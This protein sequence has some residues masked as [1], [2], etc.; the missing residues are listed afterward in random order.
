MLVDGVDC[1]ELVER[2]PC[3]LSECTTLVDAPTTRSVERATLPPDFSFTVITVVDSASVV[4]TSAATSAAT[5]DANGEQSAN[6]VVGGLDLIAWI[7]IGVGAALLVALAVGVLCYVRRRR[8][9]L[10]Q[11][12]VD[13]VLPRVANEPLPIS[14]QVLTNNA[15][16]MSSGVGDIEENAVRAKPKYDSVPPPGY[17]MPEGEP[18]PLY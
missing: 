2:V 8:R 15:I 7:L 17:D 18:E 3:V 1:P 4:A 10:L 13:T 12:D 14:P 9:Y 11:Q 16:L 5:A 6:G